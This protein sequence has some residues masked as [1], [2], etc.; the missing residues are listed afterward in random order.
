M[1]RLLLILALLPGILLKAQVPFFE[2][3]FG[4]PRPDYARSLKQSADSSI[5][6]AGY[7]IDTIAGHSDVALSKLSPAG[8][9]AWTKYY[10]D[11]LDNNCLF[12][13]DAGDGSFF[14]CGETQTAAN[15]LDGFLMKVDTAGNVLWRK[16]Y[17]GPQNESINRV[18]VLAD[19]KLAMTGFQTDAGGSNGIYVLVTDSAGNEMW[20]GNYGGQNNDA[21]RAVC[22]LP[23]SGFVVFAETAVRSAVNIA[24]EGMRFDK[25][26]IVLW[27]SIYDYGDTLPEGC[28][29]MMLLSNGNL[30]VYGESQPTA[31]TWFDF[32]FHELDVNGNTIWSR[33]TGG[34]LPDAAFSMLE[35]PGGFIGTGYSRSYSPGPNDIIV[36]GTDTVGTITW[37]Q[38]YGGPGIDI[39]YEIIPAAAG[40]YYITATGNV[41]GNDQ[42]GLLHI[43]SAGSTGIAGSQQDGDVRFFPN[44]ASDQLTITTGAPGN[45]TVQV[46]SAGGQ[47]ISCTQKNG[48]LFGLDVSGLP[49]GMFFV[50]ISGEN[51]SR[52]EKLVIR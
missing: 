13:Q 15:A 30:F 19:G 23:D 22:A 43:D 40:G 36:F 41:N 39:G 46:F 14:L 32:L 20:S 34:P 2:T 17:G 42:F 29:G 33:K 50:K 21:G 18:V 7:S 24:L 16:L 26:G 5:Y 3:Y 25:S 31:T 49:A 10:S 48:P 52:T 35:T 38:P 28:Q 4:S 27:D 37:A 47:E 11:S 51:F 12:L 9:L 44:P 1:L 8:Q 45:Y 6:I